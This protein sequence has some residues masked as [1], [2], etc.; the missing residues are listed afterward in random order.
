MNLEVSRDRGVKDNHI[1]VLDRINKK[2]KNARYDL[3][4]AV[5]AWQ[6]GDSLQSRVQLCSD[7]LLASLLKI[8]KLG[9]SARERTVCCGNGIILTYRFN[10]GDLQS[11]REVLLKEAYRLPFELKPKLMV[12]LG[13][14]IGLVSIW[15]CRHYGVEKVIAVEANPHNVEILR[16]NF[17]DNKING[18]VVEA[19]IG[20]K[21][22]SVCF[23]LSDYSN[24]GK[25][26]FDNPVEG[27]ETQVEIEMISMP[28]LLANLSPTEEIDLLK[29]DI[30]GG[31]EQLLSSNLFWLKRIK[32]I[33]AEF[34]P[35]K[36]DYPG[37]VKIIE[38]EGFS[39]IPAN[40]VHPDNMD[41]F[42]RK[43]VVTT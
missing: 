21:D 28:T 2:L 10:G 8:I 35:R 18:R 24:K 42:L 31:E 14:N 13:A 7:F 9:Y 22:G 23:E 37:L 38:A 4:V 15:L 3:E 32:S 29:L 25:V 11:I 36:V 19:A 20:P 40:S 30:E 41:S 39:Y 26:V 34:H 43:T 27:G 16:R 12:D 17:S 5:L 33:I 6:F 1:S